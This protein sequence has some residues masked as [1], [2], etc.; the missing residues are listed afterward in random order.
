MAGGPLL[1]VEVELAGKSTVRLRTVL[2][3]HASWIAAGKTPAVIYVCGTPKRA[4]SVVR[5]ADHVGLSTDLHTLRV[6]VL[7]T[8]RQAAV[9]A[10]REVTAC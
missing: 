10:R 9:D 1:P 4:A 7:D 8:I 3:L 6:E 5:H 2:A